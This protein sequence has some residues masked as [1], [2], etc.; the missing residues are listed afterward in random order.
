MIVS[1]NVSTANQFLILISSYVVTHSKEPR[2]ALVQGLHIL[3]N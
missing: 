1:N 3:G 2:D